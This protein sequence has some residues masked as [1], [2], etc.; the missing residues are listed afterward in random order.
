ME[1]RVVQWNI[2]HNTDVMKSTSK[3]NSVVRGNTTYS[4]PS[5]EISVKGKRDKRASQ[6]HG[7]SQYF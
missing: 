7:T 3:L 4:Q 6:I 1:L 2:K 5:P